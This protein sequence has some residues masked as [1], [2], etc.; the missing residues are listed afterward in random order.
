MATLIG[1][2]KTSPSCTFEYDYRDLPRMRDIETGQS[3]YRQ[4][5]SFIHKKL[6]R[7]PGVLGVRMKRFVLD[8]WLPDVH[9]L[10]DSWHFR[11]LIEKSGEEVRE[12]LAIVIEALGWDIG[13]MIRPSFGGLDKYDAL[14]RF[15]ALSVALE[16]YWN[17]RNFT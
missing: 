5:C 15:Q 9:Q 13:S 10:D 7:T 6:N 17:K 3:S 16:S 1:S 12:D 11:P 8:A 4:Y 14:A 2:P